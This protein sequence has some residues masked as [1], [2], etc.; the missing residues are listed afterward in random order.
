MVSVKT[1]LVN[2][3]SIKKSFGEVKF[4]IDSFGVFVFR[5]DR[6]WC[7]WVQLR[8]FGVLRLS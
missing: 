4:N 6:F 1:G 5:L 7:S 3:G 2:S 8:C